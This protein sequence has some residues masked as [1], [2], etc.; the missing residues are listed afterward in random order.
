M[1]VILEMKTPGTDTIKPQ[2]N[3]IM[4]KTFKKKLMSSELLASS[5]DIY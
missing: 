5:H 1:A 2:A 4:K 3:P